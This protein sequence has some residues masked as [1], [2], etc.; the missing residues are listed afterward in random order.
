MEKINIINFAVLTENEKNKLQSIGNVKNFGAAIGQEADPTEDD[1][2]NI[3]SKEEFEVLI[4]NSAPVTKKVI[5]ILKNT[6]LIICARGNP[7]N[8]DVEYCKN[9]SIIVTH[10]P[11]R[12]ANAV[13]E[14][15]IS[16]I[17]SSMRNIPDSI[18]ALKN[19]ECTLDL[20]L[21]KVDRNKKDVAWMHPS[22][23]YEPYYKFSGNEIIGKKLG[24]I[25]FGFIGQKVAE[26]AMAL[27]MEI[28]VYDPYIPKEIVH[29]F[30]ASYMEFE[31]ILKE[32][33]VISLH[34]KSSNEYL[35]K[36]EHFNLMKDSSIIIN[37]ARSTLIDN[38]ALIE[39]LKNKKIRCAVLDVFPY[40]PL[41]SYDPML[42]NIE[43]L[44]LTPHIAGASKDV[45]IHQS[46]MVIE[47]LEAYICKKEIPYLAK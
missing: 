13:A 7:V 46:K 32:S 15:T 47:S 6:K 9:K 22:L 33:D 30:N 14:Y 23:K 16:M 18:L 25:G 17:I 10:T 4:V 29:K 39:A 40:E 3:L 45:V 31:D 43:G 34:A 41:S 5:D 44:I 8:V 27:G 38:Y 37:T 21:D 26:K 11:G 12:N 2:I 42:D 19:K 28:C 20:P 35:I 24:L 1:M 36:K